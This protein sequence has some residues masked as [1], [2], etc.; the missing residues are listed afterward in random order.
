[1]ISVCSR[2]P[3]GNT[4]NLHLEI[5]RT[6]E[7]KAVAGALPRIRNHTAYFA[8]RTAGSLVHE[9]GAVAIGNH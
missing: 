4:R 2:L 9:P 1:M 8:A 3:I 6:P 5:C 7:G